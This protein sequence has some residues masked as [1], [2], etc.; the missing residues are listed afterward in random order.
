[1]RPAD[2]DHVATQDELHHPG[3]ARVE[4]VSLP[5][6]Y[7]HK[8]PDKKRPKKDKKPVEPHPEEKKPRGVRWAFL[9]AAIVLIL[10]VLVALA[11]RLFVVDMYEVPTSSMSP[12]IE[13]GDFIFAEKISLH[14]RPIA[15]GDIVFFDDPLIEGRILVKRVIAVSGQ[16]VMI[17]N[18]I[19]Y[20]DGVGTFEPYTHDTR[21]YPLSSS[22]QTASIEYPYT[23]PEGYIWVMGDD[24]GNSLDSRIFGAVSTDEILGRALF[25]A[26][27]FEAFG[28]LD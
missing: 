11:L 8:K 17:S 7:K 22:S 16:Q 18:G 1:M 2:D 10:A 13:I 24:R 25:R 5:Y 6:V 14:Y 20:V 23:V 9:N 12:T 26:W 28:F 27:P 4:N 21:S 3:D 19:V 15:R